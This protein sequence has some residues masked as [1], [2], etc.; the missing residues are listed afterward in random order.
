MNSAELQLVMAAEDAMK[1]IDDAISEGL[2]R[3]VFIEVMRHMAD[4]E[5]Y[6]D[7]VRH[8]ENVGPQIERILMASKGDSAAFARLIGEVVRGGQILH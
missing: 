7:L 3:I 8:M 6:A 5:E 2:G 4:G 1:K